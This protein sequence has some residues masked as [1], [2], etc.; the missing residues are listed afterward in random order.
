M[1]EEEVLGKA[2]DGKLMK[3]LLIYLRPYK[4][5]VVLGILLTWSITALAS[6]RLRDRG[7]SPW[8]AVVC[9]RDSIQRR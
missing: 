2:Y 8:W 4:W 1:H 6:K 5:Y 3:R 9:S 7:H